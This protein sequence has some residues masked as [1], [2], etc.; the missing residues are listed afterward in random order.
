MDDERF[1]LSR[2]Q[3]VQA[4][5]Q[6]MEVDRLPLHVD[7]VELLG[8]YE[9]LPFPPVSVDATEYLQP[10]LLGVGRELPRHHASRLP[11][12]A[13]IAV[14]HIVEGPLERRDLPEEGVG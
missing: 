5:E 4:D 6:V 9:R 12:G 11:F 13:D 10:T 7:E 8:L 2:R 3:L 14:A 1:L